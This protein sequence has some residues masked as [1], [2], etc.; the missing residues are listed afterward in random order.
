MKHVLEFSSIVVEYL[1]PHLLW[2]GEGGGTE[3]KLLAR[4]TSKITAQRGQN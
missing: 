2:R 4:I 3:K 1:L